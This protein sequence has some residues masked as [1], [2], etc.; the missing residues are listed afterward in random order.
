MCAKCYGWDMST[1]QLVEEGLPVG[2]IAAQSIG[3]PGTQ[4]TLRTFHTGGIASRAI[5]EREQKA[6]QPGKILYRDINAVAFNC[7]GR[8]YEGG[9]PETQRRNRYP[10]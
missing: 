6:T 2:I 1:G 8:Q 3:E 5:L 9:C 10:G 4:L 7:R